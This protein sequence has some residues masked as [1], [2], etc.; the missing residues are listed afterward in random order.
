MLAA[1]FKEIQ[2]T[3]QPIVAT[4]INVKCW[5]KGKAMKE[6]AKIKPQK[7]LLHLQAQKL[8][9]LMKQTETVPSKIFK[10]Y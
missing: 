1:I 9:V 2:P 4:D 7:F 10:T 8:L 5:A 3:I 6:H